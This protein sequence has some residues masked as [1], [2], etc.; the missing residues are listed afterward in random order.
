[1][2]NLCLS[3]RTYFKKY[4]IKTIQNPIRNVCATL[5]VIGCDCIVLT[6]IDQ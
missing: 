6:Y 4:R 5:F 2:E 1:M 3:A